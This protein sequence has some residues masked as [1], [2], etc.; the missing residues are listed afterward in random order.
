MT[1]IYSEIEAGKLYKQL[2]GTITAECIIH[3]TIEFVWLD[4]YQI[5]SYLFDNVS[6]QLIMNI[7]IPSHYKLELNILV[8]Y[9]GKRLS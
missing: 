3:Q 9:L 5:S 4:S 1:V 7:P 6:L 8:Y 2:F